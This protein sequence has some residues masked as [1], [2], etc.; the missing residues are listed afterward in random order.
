MLHIKSINIER[1]IHPGYGFA[2]PRSRLSRP[3]ISIRL[4]LLADEGEDVDALE[5]AMSGGSLAVVGQ[6]MIEKI[7]KATED[8]VAA[9]EEL[10][11]EKEYLEKKIDELQGLTK[12]LL[13]DR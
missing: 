12:R 4:E 6:S 2:G 10:R 1:S 13:E 5:A 3:S 7:E 8:A 11:L 9:V